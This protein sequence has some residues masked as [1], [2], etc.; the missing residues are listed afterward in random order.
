MRRPTALRRSRPASRPRRIATGANDLISGITPHMAGS[1]RADR[2]WS[3][4][5]GKQGDM[6]RRNRRGL[7]VS[8]EV[9]RRSLRW[10]VGGSWGSKLS[11]KAEGLQVRH[12]R[13][14]WSSSRDQ[15]MLAEGHERGFLTSRRPRRCG[16][17]RAEQRAGRRSAQ[18]PGGA[19]HRD[20]RGRMS[21]DAGLGTSSPEPGDAVQDEEEAATT[22]TARTNRCEDRRRRG[23]PRSLL[24]RPS[25]GARRPRWT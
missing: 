9:G 8:G 25:G 12:G 16:G 5:T 23:R 19:R 1:P 14:P 20:R 11:N 6:P 3:S 17:G 13:H 18:L 22:R 10:G 4:R 24:R 15:A 7:V 21:R 2:S